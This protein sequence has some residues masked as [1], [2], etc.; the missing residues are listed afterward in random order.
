MVETPQREKPSRANRQKTVSSFLRYAVRPRKGSTIIVRLT[1][2]R[3]FNEGSTVEACLSDA[4]TTV[5]K[6]SADLSGDWV[7]LRLRCPNDRVRFLDILHPGIGR[8]E[9]PLRSMIAVE[10]KPRSGERAIQRVKSLMAWAAD[11]GIHDARQVLSHRKTSLVRDGHLRNAVALTGSDTL[12][13]TLPQKSNAVHLRFWV[14]APSVLSENNSILKVQVLRHNRWLELTSRRCNKLGSL[15]WHQMSE[16]LRGEM[17]TANSD[18]CTKE[19]S[20]ML[21]Q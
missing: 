20:V 19:R 18:S 6:T 14:S 13:L 10:V 11:L 5:I 2:S 15:H 4:S 1:Y 16:R 7:G 12:R 21:S 17:M 3:R 9:V 8:R